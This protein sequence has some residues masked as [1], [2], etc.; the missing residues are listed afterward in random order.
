MKVKIITAAAIPLMMAG[1]ANADHKAHAGFSIGAQLGYITQESKISHKF[2]GG[3]QLSKHKDFAGRGVAGGINV[4]YGHVCPNLIFLGA[5]VKWDGT[6]LTGKQSEGNLT[7]SPQIA[8]RLKMSNAVGVALKAGGVVCHVL[9]YV[10]VGYLSADWKMSTNTI[11]GL[12]PA[13]TSSSS[14]N[15]RS[16]GLELG[17]GIDV[18][19]GDKFAMG[20]EFTHVEYQKLSKMHVIGTTD[21]VKVSA[22]PRTNAFMLRAKYRIY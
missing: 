1:L 16:S 5:E 20:G 12:L 18:P 7:S 14:K 13:I 10:K 11:L 15:K 21:Y 22:K 4:A 8:H 19:L 9:P 6:N 3:L 17:L 2:Q